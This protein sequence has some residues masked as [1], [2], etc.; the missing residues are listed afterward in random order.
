MIGFEHFDEVVSTAPTTQEILASLSG[1]QKL[2]ILNGFAEEVPVRRLMFQILVDKGAIGHLY[3]KLKEIRNLSKALMRG[4]VLITPAVIGDD[5]EVLEAEVYNTP[6][7]TSSALLAAVA[8]DFSDDFTEGQVT[9]VLGKMLEY[10]RSTKDGNW[11]YY[12]QGV[13]K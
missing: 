11:A 5:G 1:A 8:D 12:S 3:N 7:E 6:P 2:A 10:S 4:E 13:I 9:A